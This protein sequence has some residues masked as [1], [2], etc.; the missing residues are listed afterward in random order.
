MVGQFYDH[1]GDIISLL[2][3]LYNEI[4]VDIR[5][6]SKMKSLSIKNSN[7]E[8]NVGR[9]KLQMAEKSLPSYG[10]QALIEGVLMRGKNI[11]LH[12][13]ENRMEL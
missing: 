2:M 11:S 10:G 4:T 3:P 6:L 9:R 13:S 1:F 12:L 5:N 8:Y 7:I